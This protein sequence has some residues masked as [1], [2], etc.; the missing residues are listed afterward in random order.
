[1]KFHISRIQNT[2]FDDVNQIYKTNP[3]VTFQHSLNFMSHHEGRFHDESIVVRFGNIVEAYLFAARS[4][5][6]SS[7]VVSHPGATFSGFVSRKQLRGLEY[8]EILEAVLQHFKD[9]GYKK[10]VYRDVPQIYCGVLNGDFKY[11]AFKNRAEIESILLS[12]VV[13]LSKTQ[14]YSSRRSRILRKAPDNLELS[15]DW[16]HVDDYWTILSENLSSRHKASPVHTLREIKLLKGLFLKEIALLTAIDKRS[17]VPVAG[18]LIFKSE[19]VWKAQ[20]IAS[21]E[22]GRGIGAADFLLDAIIR[23]GRA[24]KIQFFDL[25]TSNEDSGLVLND[26]LYRFKSEFGGEG[27]AYEQYRFQL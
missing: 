22:H 14:T 18:V 8:V 9:A 2:D 7:V 4:M 13:D 19:R 27:V 3:N 12:C 23:L 24:D 15:G 20:Y 10:F 26:G 16:S 17:G 25:G 11:S 21:S 1:M 5:S 6:D